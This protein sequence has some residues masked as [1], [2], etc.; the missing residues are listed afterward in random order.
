MRIAVCDDEELMLNT[1]TSKL[2]ELYKKEFENITIQ[3]FCDGKVLEANHRIDPFDIIFLDIDMPSINGLDTAEVIRKYDRNVLLIFISNHE[4]LVYKSFVVQPYRFIRKNHLEDLEEAT[5][6]SVKTIMKG[7][8]K[9]TLEGIKGK[10]SIKLS[11]IIAFTSIGHTVYL[12]SG[13]KK[14]RIM[15]TLKK[16]DNQFKDLGFVRA[17]NSYLVNCRKIISI[18]KE[19]VTMEDGSQIPVSRRQMQNVKDKFLGCSGE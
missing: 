8:Y 15:S 11:E 1:I 7:K 16:L 14:I 2:T 6:A 10:F 19:S 4:E 12:C 3:G 13:N 17:H 18:D 9:V 5:T